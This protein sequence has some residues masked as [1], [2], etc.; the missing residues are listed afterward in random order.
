MF[1]RPK[2][3]KKKKHRGII[4]ANINTFEKTQKSITVIVLCNKL[5]VFVNGNNFKFKLK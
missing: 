4:N 3:T 5:I 1:F 2:F